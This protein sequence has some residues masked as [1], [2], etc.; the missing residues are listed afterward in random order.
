[1]P[2]V[3][4]GVN[5]GPPSKPRGFTESAVFTPEADPFPCAGAGETGDELALGGD[6]GFIEGPACVPKPPDSLRD[7]ISPPRVRITTSPAPGGGVTAPGLLPIIGCGG[8]GVGI[9]KEA[10]GGTCP[11]PVEGTGGSG[12]AVPPALTLDSCSVCPRP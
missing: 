11:E 12:A 7:S 6:A 3:S 5:K 8:G 9:L 1:M 4:L 2:A 10:G